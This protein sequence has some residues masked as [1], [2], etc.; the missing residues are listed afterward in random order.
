[1]IGKPNCIQCGVEMPDSYTQR[2]YCSRRCKSKWSKTH[3][4]GKLSGG[5]KCRVCGTHIE[6]TK[7]Q[8]NKWI[9]S[10]ECRKKRLTDSIRKFHRVR[11]ERQA[12]YR[13]RT[14]I[15]CG[16]DGNLVRFYKWNPNAPR[17]CESC[18]ETRVLECAHKPDFERT[19]EGRSKANSQWPK[20]VWVLCPTC[21]ALIDRMNYSPTELGLSL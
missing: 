1:M 11:P 14:R 7:R 18:G 9:C 5:H 12:E 4:W 16:P 19:G 15:K 20:M 17:K 13:K 2:K 6:L 8:A 3:P 10:K 21:H